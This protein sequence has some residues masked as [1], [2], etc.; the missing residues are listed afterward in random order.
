MAETQTTE[1]TAKREA[2][3]ELEG[4]QVLVGVLGTILSTAP[5]PIR[6]TA[7]T[8]L[9]AILGVEF[10]THGHDLEAYLKTLTDGVRKIYPAYLKEYQQHVLIANAMKQQHN[11]TH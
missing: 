6:A 8:A 4:T 2:D 9:V 7:V 10:S 1:Q 3:E 5:A 11:K